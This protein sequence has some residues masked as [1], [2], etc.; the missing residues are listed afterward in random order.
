MT[1]PDLI[2]TGVPGLDA[3]LL[4]GLP[5][6]N[7]TLLIGP[8]GSGKTTLGLQAI[9]EGARLFGEPGLIVLFEVSPEKVTRDARRFGWDLEDFETK[10]LVKV[11]YI[12]RQAFEDE[13]KQPESVLLADARALGV[14]RI[15]IDSYGLPH[16]GNGVPRERFL[17]LLEGL[18]REALTAILSIETVDSAGHPSF[19][20]FL[21]DTVICLGADATSGALVRSIEIKKSRGQPYLTGRHS[22]DIQDGRGIIVYPRAQAR[23]LVSSAEAATELARRLTCGVP[24][25]D[26]MLGGGYLPRSSTL[27]VGA[28]GVGK[29]V[30]GLHYLVEGVRCGER[31]LFATLDEPPDQVVRNAASVGL[32]L[33]DALKAD[34]LRIHYE[35]PRE[36]VPDRNFAEIEALVKELRPTRAVLDSISG[37]RPLFPQH[38]GRFREF[39]LA[40]IALMK[41]YGVTA[42]YNHE[43]PEFAGIGSLTGGTAA[44]SSA[45]DNIILLNWVELGDEYRHAITIAKARAT[46]ST[47]ITRECEIGTGTGMRVLDRVIPAGVLR[48]PFAGYRSLTARAPERSREQDT[49]GIKTE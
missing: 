24:G 38:E 20:L 6:G 2:G 14:K 46:A 21:G 12:T 37:Y 4:G 19:E 43:N 10:G 39:L 8:V 25:L 42:L 17:Q 3:A 26:D 15:F 45:V 49:L 33:T 32:D 36:L 30:L 31:G 16:A 1:Q 11:I 29:S 44:L 41:R 22:L 35:S 48:L 9:C 40:L 47:R 13:I 7:V 5:R 34:M 28:S 23:V 18:Q 27:V